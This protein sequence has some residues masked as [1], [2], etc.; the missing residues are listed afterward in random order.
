MTF[1]EAAVE[2]LRVAG[3]PL[4]YKKI[5]EIAIKRGL[6]SHIGKTPE[7]TM[8]SRLNQVVRKADS[9]SAVLRM[10][11]GVFSLR[12]WSEGEEK[13]P[14]RVAETT[15]TARAIEIGEEPLEISPEPEELLEIVELE[16]PLEASL[17]AE[18]P[19]RRRRRRRR[20]RA[21]ALEEEAGADS[22]EPEGLS[23]VNGVHKE[24]DL[25]EI[26]A[27]EEAVAE[28]EREEPSPLLEELDLGEVQEPV[29]EV[30]AV[31]ELRAAEPRP[32]APVAQESAPAE[33]HSIAEAAWKVFQSVEQRAWTEV[34]LG[35][36]VFGQRMVRFH[37]LNREAAI[38]AAL[39]TDNHQRRRRGQRPLFASAQPGQWTLTDWTLGEE[40]LE[41]ER[42][43]FS[44]AQEMHGMAGEAVGELLSRLNRAGL[45]HLTL[46][47]L[48]RLGYRDL[49]VS[50]RLGDGGVVFTGRLLRGLS[51]TRVAVCLTGHERPLS[52]DDV[53]SLR[54]TLH[55]YA[56]AEGVILALGDI[57]AD[58]LEESRVPNLAR[59]TVLD[60]AHFVEMLL[61]E[62]LGVQTSSVPVTF[63]DSAF[64]EALGVVD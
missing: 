8:G 25:R 45:E 64:F 34:E 41:G 7:V 29:A 48:E 3:R 39:V 10:R 17:I 43:L 32:V 26:Y 18:E 49:K 59:I 20:R 9:D 19:E 55:H 21:E 63:V 58:A 54:G 12:A 57:G 15:A 5:T 4:H 16:E 52:Q 37:T 36:Q 62:G 13:A 22:D 46:L 51:E 2:V 24:P 35:E 27:L 23:E 47:L 50:K 53:T 33:L 28:L 38:R 6:L 11:P 40:V 30:E 1:Y 61:E 42:A 60:R 56:A 31:A 44:I 14:S